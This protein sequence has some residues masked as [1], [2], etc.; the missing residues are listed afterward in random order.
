MV[1]LANIGDT[2]GMT[3][4]TLLSEKQ[5]AHYYVGRDVG[6]ERGRCKGNLRLMA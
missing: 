6:P 1:A 2:G 4:K 5:A 3:V